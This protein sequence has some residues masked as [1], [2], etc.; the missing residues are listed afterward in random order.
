[1]PEYVVERTAKI[2]S[3]KFKKSLNGAKVLL[4]GVAFKK[5]IADLRESPAL[6]IIKKLEEEGAII[7]YYDPYISEFTS[8]KKEYKSLK[9]LTK[10]EIREDDIVIIT[11]A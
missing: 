2:L 6:E 5:D 10:E 8:N 11:T 1:M 9:E 4:L 3:R 7:S